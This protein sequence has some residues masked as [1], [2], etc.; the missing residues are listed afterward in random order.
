MRRLLAMLMMALFVVGSAACN[1]RDGDEPAPAID[2]AL[3]AYLSEARALHHTANVKEDSGDLAGAAAAGDRGPATGAD[4][5]A[6]R[7]PLRAALPAG[8]QPVPGRESGPALCL[9][10][11]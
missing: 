7:L 9:R 4:G 10:G 2:A 5:P 11:P 3:M 8:L 6:A 1:R